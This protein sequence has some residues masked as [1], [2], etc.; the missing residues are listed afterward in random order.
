MGHEGAQREPDR[1]GGVDVGRR[2]DA[3]VRH[4]REIGD[5][6][7]LAVALELDCLDSG[8]TDLDTPADIG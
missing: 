7:A 2:E 1:F 6:H 4:D 3:F 5:S 8:G